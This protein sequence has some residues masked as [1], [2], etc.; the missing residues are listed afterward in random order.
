MR[1][2]NIVW[3]VALM[4]SIALSIN[5][6]DPE[7]R[8][9]LIIGNLN[10]SPI[11]ASPGDTIL[12]P[13][14]VKIDESITITIIPVAT[15][16]NYIVRRDTLA[17]PPSPGCLYFW[18]PNP[19]QPRSGWTSQTLWWWD[20]LGECALDTDYQWQLIDEFQ[21][22]VS[23]NNEISGDTTRFMEGYDP[24]NGNILFG[25]P[26]GINSLIPAKL[27]GTMVFFISGDIDETGIINGNDIIYLVNYLKGIGPAPNLFPSADVNGDCRINGLDVVYLLNYLK[28]LGGAPQ[29]GNCN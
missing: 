22:V 20:N 24:R 10:R 3:A 12:L 19:N 15:D 1:L 2:R 21:A 4:F 11:F 7:K 17:N 25:L 29:R 9:S 27:F 5:A 23:T 26:D 28:G 16:N 18:P 13:V 6:Q 8:D 14:W